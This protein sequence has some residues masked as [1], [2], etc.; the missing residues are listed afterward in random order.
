MPTT[1]AGWLFLFAAIGALGGMATIYDV[2]QKA[3]KDRKRPTIAAPSGV[4]I[5]RSRAIVT[6]VLFLLSFGLSVWGFIASGNNKQ[7]IRQARYGMTSGG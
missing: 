1:E 2:A 6:A 7:V 3:W 5:S 4:L